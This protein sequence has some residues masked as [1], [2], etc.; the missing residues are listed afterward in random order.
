MLVNVSISQQ[1]HLNV[2]TICKGNELLIKA[3]SFV[4]SFKNMKRKKKTKAL[5][6]PGGVVRQ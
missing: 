4:V 2:G 1:V 5:K 6:F 3:Y